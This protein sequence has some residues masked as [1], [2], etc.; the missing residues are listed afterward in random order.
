[1][2]VSTFTGCT[3]RDYISLRAE[4]PQECAAL[5]KTGMSQFIPQDATTLLTYG[6]VDPE[7]V[8][9]RVYVGPHKNAV[10]DQA[11]LDALDA[12]P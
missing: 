7:T 5:V 4:T 9:L 11:M 8:E 2:K 3:D 10:P 6:A 12:V 1:M